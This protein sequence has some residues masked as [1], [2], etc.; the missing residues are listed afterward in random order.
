[1][2]WRELYRAMEPILLRHRSFA[3]DGELGS[4]SP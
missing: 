3:D 4:V 1:M 2:F